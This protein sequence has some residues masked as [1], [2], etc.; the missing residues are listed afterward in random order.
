MSK[1]YIIP[2][3]GAD[4]R[5][6]KNIDL[7]GHEVIPINWIEPSK[8]D[9]LAM[10]AQKLI[11]QYNIKPDSVLIGNSLGGMLAVE[12]AKVL[13]M[14]KVILISSIKTS[15]E[16][17][18]YFS[19]FKNVPIQKLVPGKL[20]TSMGSMIRPVFGGMTKDDARVFME[21]LKGT[22]PVFIEWAMG[23][24]LAWKNDIVPPN[25]YHITGDKDLV[26]DYKKIKG[27]TIVKG[28]THIMIFDKAGEINKLL[29]PILYQQ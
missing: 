12:I 3:L 22:S 4:T 17:P 10:Y 6:Y 24:I 28:G 19:F 2:G 20:M 15:D 25:T 16:A 26:F 11:D 18:G 1:I 21:M 7:H 5:I 23:A 14:E 13:P 8:A 27:A 29:K 9:T